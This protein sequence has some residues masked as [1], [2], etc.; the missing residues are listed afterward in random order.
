MYSFHKRPRVGTSESATV[1]CVIAIHS[2][3]QPGFGI[4]LIGGEFLV[5]RRRRGFHLPSFA[6]RERLV[7]LDDESCG[8][9]HEHR[10]SEFVRRVINRLIR[11]RCR[12]RG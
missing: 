4:A 9:D 10:A 1:V 12:R 3:I 6:V 2:V 5:I 7:V 8:I 11:V